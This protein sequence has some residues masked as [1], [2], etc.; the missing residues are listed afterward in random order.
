MLFDGRGRRTIGDWLMCAPAAIGL[1]GAAVSAVGTMQSA[2]S[3]AAVNEYNARVERIN[4]RSRRWEGL[5]A[6]E[7][8]AQKYDKLQGQ[9]TAGYSAAGVDPFYGSALNIFQDTEQ[10]RGTDQSRNYLDHESKAI[11]HENRA[12]Q[13]EFSAKQKRKAGSIG[14]AST[15]IGGLGGALKG[16]AGGFGA[17]LKIG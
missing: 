9:Q 16:G 3:E 1:V 2:N 8:I 14:A 15:L 13:E 4:A 11:A 17:T 6:S 10:A 5:A 7:D 12:K